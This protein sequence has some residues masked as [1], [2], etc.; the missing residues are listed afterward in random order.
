[1]VFREDLDGFSLFLDVEDEVLEDIDE[2]V[3]LAGAPDDCL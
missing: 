1:V 2:P 3:L